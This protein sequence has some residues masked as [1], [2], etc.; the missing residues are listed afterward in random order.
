MPIIIENESVL[1]QIGTSLS[2]FSPII[3]LYYII[4]FRR[5]GKLGM[6]QTPVEGGLESV[7]P[8]RYVNSVLPFGYTT[9]VS[10]R[11]SNPG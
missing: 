5:F 2:T 3:N 10:S 1:G 9:H 11:K 6:T 8:S 4:P 7:S